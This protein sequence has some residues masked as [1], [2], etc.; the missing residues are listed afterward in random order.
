M[1]TIIF[2]RFPFWI[3]SLINYTVF[4]EKRLYG[5]TVRV[6]I[7]SRRVSMSRFAGM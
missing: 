7:P 1:G 4:M 3:I 6:W 2:L 5:K